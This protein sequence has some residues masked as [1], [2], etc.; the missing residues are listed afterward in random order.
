MSARPPMQLRPLPYF[1]Q[2]ALAHEL[3]HRTAAMIVAAGILE[4]GAQNTSPRLLS[5][6]LRSRSSSVC[7]LLADPHT[8]Q[9]TLVE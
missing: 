1:D 5:M 4:I 7:G 3:A 2:V 6:R 8:R 9:Y